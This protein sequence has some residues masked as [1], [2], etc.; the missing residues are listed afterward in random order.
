[1]VELLGKSRTLH[2]LATSAVVDTETALQ[3]GLVNVVAAEF[4]TELDGQLG[5]LARND[6]TMIAT[7]KQGVRRLDSTGRQAAIDAELEPF[8]KHWGSDAHRARVKAFLDK[9]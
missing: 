1:M 4:D 6:R 9:D 5:K 3:C 8:A 7:L 2:W